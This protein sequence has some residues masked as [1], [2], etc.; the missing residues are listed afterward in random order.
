MEES[1]RANIGLI[2][3]HKADIEGNLV[4]H[5]TAW[6]SNV[7]IAKACDFVIAEVDEIIPSGSIDG[8]DVHTPSIYVDALVIRET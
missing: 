4:Y 1:L 6:N 2:K 5:K 7:S 3:A 8:D